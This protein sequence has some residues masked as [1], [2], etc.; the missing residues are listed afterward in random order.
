MFVIGV[1]PALLSLFIFKKL[2]EPEKWKAAN[3][4]RLAEREAGVVGDGQKLG[5]GR[6]SCSATPA[7]GGTRSSA[8]S[9]RSPGWSGSGGSASSAST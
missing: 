2:K 9:W 4:R 1:L 5:L 8:C 7:G 3:A 6:A